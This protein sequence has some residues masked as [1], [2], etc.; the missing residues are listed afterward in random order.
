MKISILAFVFSFLINLLCIQST[1]D[2]FLECQ[3]GLDNKS[4]CENFMTALVIMSFMSQLKVHK[5]YSD[6]LGPQ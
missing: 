4:M 5:Q 6:F 2:L 1:L 3:N